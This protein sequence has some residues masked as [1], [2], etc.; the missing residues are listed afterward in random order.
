MLDKAF[1][2]GLGFLDL[3]REK[4]EA[5]FDELVERGAISREEAREKVDE[6]IKRG[7]EQRQEWQKTI[8]KEFER[9]RGEYKRVS[10]QEFQE[11]R[12]R[13]EAIE[14][15]LGIEAPLETPADETAQDETADV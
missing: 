3:T 1:A 12:S 11:L 8:D 6:L 9:L 10:A 13:V 14:K 7:D 15:K 4:A 2:A 5:V